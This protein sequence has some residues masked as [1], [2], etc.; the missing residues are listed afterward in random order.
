MTTIF[1]PETLPG[2]VG[3]T[4]GPGEWL[5]VTQE[6]IDDFARATG[7][8]QWIH[9]DVERAKSGPFGTTIAHGLLTLSMI[10]ALNQGMFKFEGF[11]MGL[12]YG[13]EKVRFPSP[14][15]VGSRLRVSAKILSYEPV[16]PMF[17]TIVEYTVDREGA[18]KPSCVAQMIFR[19][20][21]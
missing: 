7:D 2:L 18:D 4:L 16:G 20:T 14:V 19:H 1:S 6:R 15:P 9:V 17:Q 3:S 21:L 13:Y 12:N 11:K 8:H 10:A 5:E